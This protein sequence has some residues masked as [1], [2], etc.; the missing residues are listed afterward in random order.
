M[1]YKPRVLDLFCGAGGL[2]LGFERAGCKI[3]GGIELEHWPCMTHHRN[4]PDCEVTLGPTDISMVDPAA[5]GLKPG[6]VDILIGG[7]PCQGFSQVGRAKIRSLGQERER[8]RKNRLYREFIR[9]LDY[10]QPAYFVIENVQGMKTFKSSR[11][12]DQVL[13]ELSHGYGNYKFSS[14]R[15]YEVQAKVLC[16]VDYGVPQVRYR[17]FIIGRRRD[18]TDLTIRFPEAAVSEPITLHD[19]I[20]DLPR[21][22]APVLSTKSASFLINSGIKQE[23]RPKSYR[24]IPENNYQRV[25]REGSGN[26]VLNHV[27]RGHNKKDLEIF[28]LLRQGEKY[29]DLP[30]KHRR[31]RDDIFDDKYRRLKANQPCWTLTAH[32]QKDCLAYIHPRQTRSL[33]TREA[34]RIQS[35][36]DSFI[37]EGP[38]TKVFRQVGNAV[39][40]L[41]AEQVALGLVSQLSRRRSELIHRARV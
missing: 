36:P 15:G 16:A 28:A 31:Y 38:L 19:A 18:C 40:P 3:V 14:N 17:L 32:M 34:A 30:A 39:P 22:E 4:F 5:L 26:R 27:C 6:S 10:L 24:T 29:A 13:E 23:D 25:M 11:F 35:F 8:D 1:R 21:L 7:P 9:F 2:S 12:L 20:S 37:F 33:S 41:L